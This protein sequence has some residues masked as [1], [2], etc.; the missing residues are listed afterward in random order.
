MSLNRAWARDLIVW[1]VPV[2]AAVATFFAF[3]VVVRGEPVR[4]AGGAGWTAPE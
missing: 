4:D 3:L 1:V 2:F